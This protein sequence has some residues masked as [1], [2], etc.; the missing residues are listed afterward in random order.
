MTPRITARFGEVDLVHLTP[1]TGVD[2]ALPIG[3][4]LYAPT[5][6]IVSRI[7]DYGGDGLGKAVFVKTKTGYQYILG[8]LSE[9]KVRIG[10]RVFSGDL[11]ALSGN[12]GNSTGPHV[13]IGLVNGAGAFVDPQLGILG[14]VVEKAIGEAQQSVGD[15][16]RSF[17]YKVLL[18]FLEGV[19]D[20][21]VDLSYSIA[22]IGGGLAIIL[23]V[24]GWEKGTR[25]AGILTVSYV[26][27]KYL[28]G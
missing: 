20:L 5:E 22:L 7:A 25:W 21:V 28:L 11:I 26:L 16:A 17:T 1:H 6:G 4:K 19:R 18:G 24:A 15:H 12:T 14:K 23:H 13:H 8:H 27:I 9:T 2:V 3:S 10:D